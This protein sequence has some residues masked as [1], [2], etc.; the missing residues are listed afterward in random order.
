M[1]YA[2]CFLKPMVFYWCTCLLGCVKSQLSACTKGKL[3]TFGYGNL[4]CSFV[5]ETILPSIPG[6]YIEPHSLCDPSMTRYTWLIL[7]LGDGKASI[8]FNSDFFVWLEHQVKDI[9]GYLYYGIN[10]SR[11]LDMAVPK[12]K[13]TWSDW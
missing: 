13:R 11:D 10:F 2:T 5:F 12:R 9:K 3:K 8:L 1:L 6:V 7:R 4:I